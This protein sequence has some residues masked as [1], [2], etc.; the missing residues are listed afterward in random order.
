[1]HKEYFENLKKAAP[2]VMFAICNVYGYTEFEGEYYSNYLI[3]STGKSIPKLIETFDANLEP[4]KLNVMLVIDHLEANGY[5]FLSV[6]LMNDY[7]IQV[8]KNTTH[9]GSTAA[10]GKFLHYALQDA[11][12]IAV[13]HL[14]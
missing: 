5:R 10:S 11:S 14:E 13:R 7:S 8:Y 2:N 3:K 12:I 1:M 4:F 6:S 9:I